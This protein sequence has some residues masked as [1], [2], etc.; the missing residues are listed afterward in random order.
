MQVISFTKEVLTVCKDVYEGRPTTDSQMEENAASIGVLL[1][2][3]NHS[4]GS[5]QQQTKEERE[6]HAVAQKCSK[7]AEELQKEIRQVTKHQKP[8]DYRMAFIAGY[9]SIFGKRKIS[10]LYDQFC[11]H[12]KTLET[13]ILVRLWT[14]AIELQR[15]E[16]FTQLSDIMKH[17]VSQVAA[18]HT[19]MAN[20]ITRDGHQTRQQIQLIEDH[21]KQEINNVQMEVV[22]E[23]KRDRLLRSLKYESMNSRRTGLKPA[24]EATYVSIFESLDAKPPDAEALNTEHPKIRNSVEV[25]WEGFIAWLTSEKQV[26]WIQG[27][28][29]SGKSTLLKFVLQHEKTQM[30]VDRWRPNTVIVS[31]FF[32][33]PGHILQKDLRGLLC[34]LNHQLLSSEQALIGHVLSEFAFARDHETIGDWEIAQLESVFHC[35]LKQCKKSILFFIDGLDEATRPDEII[36]LLDSLLGRRNV[37]LCI[38]SRGEDVFR[39][40]FSKYDGFTLEDLTRDDMLEFAL[41][42]IPASYERYP[43]EFL[44]DLRRLLIEKAEGVFLWLVLATESVKRGLQNNDDQDTIHSRLKQLPS[45]LEQLY[46]E[47]WDRLGQDKAVYQQEAARYFSLLIANQVLLEEYDRIFPHQALQFPLNPFL[48]MLDT[49]ETWK[50]KMLDK[51]HQPV[52]SDL[53]NE[54]AKVAFGIPIKT[55]GLLVKREASFFANHRSLWPRPEFLDLIEH[56]SCGVEFLHRTL[57]DFFLHSEVGR[58][59]VA[60]GQTSCIKLRLATIILCQLRTTQYDSLAWRTKRAAVSCP[61]H[62]CV[63]ILG[64]LLAEDSTS[65][66]NMVLDLLHDLE[67]L[68]AAGLIPWDERPDW[69][70]PPPFELMLINYP[71]F[72]GFLQSHIK[73]R[74]ASHATRLLREAMRG[75]MA[76]SWREEVW[77][78]FDIQESLSTVGGDINS[79]DICLYDAYWH[80]EIG[81]GDISVP[82]F[83]FAPYESILS[84]VIKICHCQVLTDGR[85][86]DEHMRNLLAA[87]ERAPDLN[88][89]T[90]FILGTKYQYG[91]REGKVTLS[92]FNPPIDQMVSLRTFERR[93]DETLAITQ[94]TIVAEVSLGYLVEYLFK[95]MPSA[96]K[97]SMPLVAHTQR[98]L[99]TE[100]SKPYVRARF[101]VEHCLTA[102]NPA[103]RHCYRFID[104]DFDVLADTTVKEATVDTFAEYKIS[105]EKLEGY[106]NKCER[107]DGSALSVLADERLGVCRLEDMGIRPST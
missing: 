39:R 75:Y 15:H 31:H 67:S 5:V 35:I 46:A 24:H 4:A 87:L 101:L 58:T 64:Q 30:G 1:D 107:V 103:A 33:K 90:S 106:R 65:N 76:D 78:T 84:A 96:R 10:G 71:V 89:R 104:K 82:V 57:L 36:R 59:M 13:H 53:K 26:F 29:G 3:M 66:S 88:K 17:F 54:V 68:F 22:N 97:N 55:A 92:V 16:D 70:P 28:P 18:G 23:A 99:T 50:R 80:V 79:T 98:L 69:Y 27:K 77:M 95:A 83:E 72:K 40:K 37:K 44:E 93:K 14:D 45:E 74:G 9:K 56:L 19:D 34:S 73:S 42:E 85:L 32:W 38:S 12:Q 102:W 49:N 63:W 105:L 100:S 62:Y 25:A 11:K 94:A 91:A 41:A 47:M 81:R 61:V 7:A 52:V 20:L 86:A 2:E 60:Q 43:S 6:L 21:V 48:L 51:N 8:G